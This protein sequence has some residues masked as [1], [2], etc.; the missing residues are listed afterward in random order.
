MFPTSGQ[1]YVWTS[2]KEVYN[3]ECLVPTVQYGAR[4]VMIW[5]PIFSI[6]LVL[7]YS[8]RMNARVYVDILGSQ[9]HPMV[10][11][12]FPNID[13]IFQDDDSPIHTA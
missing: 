9:V 1:V 4:T 6:L 2:P 10:Q 8:E 11:V 7:H 3:P 12:L 5:A 13:A